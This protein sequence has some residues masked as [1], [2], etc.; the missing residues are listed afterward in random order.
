MFLFYPLAK[1][2]FWKTDSQRI[3]RQTLGIGTKIKGFFGFAP[4]Q[5]S[6]SGSAGSTV[7]I[8]NLTSST[9]LE[10][11]GLHAGSVAVSPESAIKL[12]TVFRCVDLLSST[13]A[14]LP[15][16]LMRKSN[17]RREP[18]TAH[19]CYSL[20]KVRP[21]KLQTSFIW[22]K[23]I[24]THALLWGNGYAKIERNGV[25]RPTS[26]KIYHPNKT[27]VVE[28]ED[29]LWYSFD[30]SPLV[31]S[32]E[33]I[34]LKLFTTDGLTGRSVIR[35]A[36]ESLSVP[37]QTQRY[38]N[39][40]FEKGARVSG[41]LSHPNKLSADSKKNLADAW[42]SVFGMGGTNAGG[43]PILDEGV[44][45]EQ[46]GIPPGDFQLLEMLKASNET[47]C[48]W[49]GVPQHLAGILDHATF[50][51][52]E[53][54]DLEY[55]KYSLDP[56]LVNFEQEMAYKILRTSELGEY[57]VHHNRNAMLRTDI[58]SRY[59]AHRTGIQNGFM[60]PND[61]REL[62]DMNPIDGGDRY[63]IQQN[64]M[65]LDMVDTVLAD[66]GQQAI[67]AL[68][69]LAGGTDTLG[70]PDTTATRKNGH[71]LNGHTPAVT[72]N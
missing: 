10:A 43:T 36:A 64:M 39:S 52:I 16:D 51:N 63:F 14:Y 31:P 9:L 44:K 59:E 7:P 53:H 12:A 49:F 50:S 47:I 57:Y 70:S 5:R 6:I 21:H 11:L 46:V 37:L 30:G 67:R 32:S 48:T 58:K 42:R 18:A 28:Y 72:P 15:L 26:L 62:E 29:D 33:V 13:A 25:Y 17:G 40:F 68:R 27:S 54:Q 2:E 1:P 22:R 24:I 20:L 56:H 34:H 35:M 8:G 60:S 61:A 71:T 55:M 3:D 38:A 69:L 4:E 65:P 23:T 19:P 41:I 45:Y 66:S